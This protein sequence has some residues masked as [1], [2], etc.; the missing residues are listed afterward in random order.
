[1]ATEQQLAMLGEYDF[2]ALFD[3]SGSMGTMDCKGRSRIAYLQESAE[4]FCRDLS[5]IDSDGIDV[6]VFNGSAIQPFQNVTAA[7]ITEIF[8]N[9]SPR[10]STPL[11]EALQVAF[12]LAGK[13]DKKDFIIVFTDGVPDDKAAVAKLISNQSHKQETDDALTILFVQVGYDMDAAS[14]LSKLDDDLTGCKFDIVDAKTM[15][16]AEKFATTADLICAAIAD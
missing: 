6:V 10:S 9:N 5:A 16:E 11:A 4:A 15:E 7:K 8:Q 2:V 14:Y 3:F 13:S 12:D 1:M